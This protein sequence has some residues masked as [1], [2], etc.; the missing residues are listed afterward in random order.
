[1]LEHQQMFVDIFTAYGMNFLITIAKPLESLLRSYIDSKDTTALCKTLNLHMDSYDQHR[2]SIAHQHS[3]NER[4]IGSLSSGLGSMGT[5]LIL[6]GPNMHVHVIERSIRYIKDAPRGVLTSIPYPCPRLLF[7]DL[8][9]FVAQRLNLFQV[10]TRT[11]HTST[12]QLVYDRAAVADRHCVQG[13]RITT[14]YK[15]I[16][17]AG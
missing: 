5:Q 11:Y 8:P 2:I 15:G 10:S 7:R 12:L 3:D 1:M 17:E 4:S 14:E 6:C 16:L 13:L 9:A